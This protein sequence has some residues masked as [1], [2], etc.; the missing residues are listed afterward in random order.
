MIDNLCSQQYQIKSNIRGNKCKIIFIVQ[1]EILKLS[2]QIRN[3]FLFSL[4]CFITKHSNTLDEFFVIIKF[5]EN[6]YRY[7]GQ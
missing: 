2:F 3:I 7:N 5:L 4:Q 1:S 6:F